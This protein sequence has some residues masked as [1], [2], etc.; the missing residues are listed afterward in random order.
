MKRSIANVLEEQINRWRSDQA[1]HRARVPEEPFEPASVITIS[2]EAGAGGA[3]VA[4]QVGAMLEIPV[5]DGEIVEHIAK[6][7]K[8]RVQTV[9]TLDE[10]TQ[11]RLDDYLT[12][13]FRERN[14]DQSDY[15]RSLTKTV[16]ALWG[17]GPCVM[18]GRGAGHVV[19]RRYSLA[20]R[21]VAPVAQRVKAKARLL[22]LSEA[23]ATRLV[24]RLDA[25]REA[26]VKRFFGKSIHDPLCYD[27]VVNLAGFD[28]T[29]AADI[30][31]GAYR[32]KTASRTSRSQA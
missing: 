16:T 21:L 25:E 5:Y 2:R 7:S 24:L 27:L 8:V 30:I 18:L 23:E 3:E 26:F 19:F 29:A 17:H 12:A 10:R 13:L 1:N 4:E 28:A 32:R 15:L 6:T 9:E 11:N 20:V 31:A 22:D 14:F